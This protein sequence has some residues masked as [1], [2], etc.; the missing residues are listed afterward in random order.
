LDTVIRYGAGITDADIIMSDGVSLE[1]AGVT[2]NMVLL[3]VATNLRVHEDPVLSGAAELLGVKLDAGEA[4][5]LFSFKWRA[6]N[7]WGSKRN[8]KRH[9]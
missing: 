9:R 3:P 8:G 5:K 1:E 7:R 6:L 2:P 4:G